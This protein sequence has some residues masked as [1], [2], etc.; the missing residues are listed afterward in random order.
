VLKESIDLYRE[1]VRGYL[2]SLIDYSIFVINNSLAPFRSKR[3]IKIPKRR[4]FV[5]LGSRLTRYLPRNLAARCWGQTSRMRPTSKNSQNGTTKGEALNVRVGSLTL[6]F[7]AIA[8]KHTRAISKWTQPRE[9]ESGLSDLEN[10]ICGWHTNYEQFV[11]SLHCPSKRPSAKLR[12]PSSEDKGN[13]IKA[14]R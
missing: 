7:P 12:E 9:R 3:S 11:R 10:Y 13:V 14:A 4:I 5:A 1:C 2:I 6:L 8:G